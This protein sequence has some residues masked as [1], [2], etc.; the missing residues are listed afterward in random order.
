MMKTKLRYG[1]TANFI[2][3]LSMACQQSFAASPDAW[4][5]HYTEVR[6]KCLQAS[7]LLQAKLAGD[8]VDLPDDIGF[9]MLIVRG[10]YKFDQKT[11]GTEVCFLN[12]SN[13][14]VSITGAD[15]LFNQ[16]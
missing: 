4:E 12:R 15:Q 5:E 1:L 7:S 2:F 13:R 16:Q 3:M 10:V 14:S 11:P 8:V 6:Q 9:S